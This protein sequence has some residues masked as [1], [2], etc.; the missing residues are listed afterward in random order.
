MIRKKSE[1]L[2]AC[3]QLG[4]SEGS[5]MIDGKPCQKKGDNGN[6][7][8]LEDFAGDSGGGRNAYLI[9]KNSGFL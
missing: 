7:R 6:C 1:C 4:L 3:A 5:E 9:C 8:Q 2:I